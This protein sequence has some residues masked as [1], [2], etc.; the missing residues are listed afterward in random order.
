MKLLKNFNYLFL[1]L[2]LL[3]CTNCKSNFNYDDLPKITYEN[4]L[5]LNGE[6]LVVC[7]QTNCENCDKLKDIMDEYSKYSLD[8]STAMQLYGLS[9]NLS[10]NKKICLLS[11]ES[12]PSDMMN[13]TDYTKIK[14]KSTP[15]LLVIK[16]HQLIKV[17]SDYNTEK[18]VTETKNYLNQLMK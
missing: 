5:N 18:P 8:N 17:I 14:V 7:Y 4:V 10:I 9:I 12:Y 16:N 1:L 2:V 6:Y 11:S 15:S 3:L 13:T